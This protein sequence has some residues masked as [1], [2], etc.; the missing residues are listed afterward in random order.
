MLTAKQIYNF[1]RK[2]QWQ[3][4]CIVWTASTDRRGYGSFRVGAKN[5]RAHRVWYEHMFGAV[6]AGYELDHKCRVR[7][8]VNPNHLRVVTHAENMAVAISAVKRYCAKGHPFSG[9]NLYIVKGTIQR[10]CRACRRDGRGITKG[11]YQWV[12]YVGKY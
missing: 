9:D 8:C 1:T 6:P 10:K 3:G 5:K 4:S 11:G 12:K 7:H 2:V